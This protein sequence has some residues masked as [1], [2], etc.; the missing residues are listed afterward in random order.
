MRT[1]PGRGQ[2]RATRLTRGACSGWWGAL[3]LLV[4][5]TGAFAADASAPQLHIEQIGS[6]WVDARNN[7]AETARFQVRASCP[8]GEPGTPPCSGLDGAVEITEA[9]SNVYNGRHG[10]TGLPMRVDLRGGR[11][12]FTLRSLAALPA[13]GAA[14]P[15]PARIVAR[16]GPASAQMTVA[17]WVDADGDGRIDWLARRI[18]RV[19]AAGRRSAIAPLRETLDAVTRWRQ[20]PDADCG[21]VIPEH[22]T[23]V[24]VGPVC[25]NAA[26]QNTHRLNTDNQLAAT[27]L[28][29]ARHVWVYRNPGRAG[30]PRI[31]GPGRVLNEQ[32]VR[33]HEI[34]AEAFARRYRDALH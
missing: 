10:A 8:A 31:Y 27:L 25:R 30:L 19:L 6:T 32:A 13:A 28:H 23:E 15:A 5:G 16:L 26:G 33:A 1:R 2:T 24:G 17:Q 7:Y 21:R 29:E 18:E 22:P 20:S 34:D 14:R 11:A 9:G 3:V 12:Q 4:A